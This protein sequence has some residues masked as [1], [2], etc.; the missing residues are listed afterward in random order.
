[1][2]RKDAGPGWFVIQLFILELKTILRICVMDRLTVSKS[3]NPVC[4]T[5]VRLTLQSYRD[6]H[7][8]FTH[9]SRSSTPS[10]ESLILWL[11]TGFSGI[12]A[13]I[14][15]FLFASM[16]MPACLRAANVTYTA[17]IDTPSL[18]S[19]SSASLNVQGSNLPC[20]FQEWSNSK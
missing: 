2:A 8:R 20:F 5:G 1:M 19:L 12:K 7:G 3:L 18:P 9:K 14:F 6:M 17:G 11:A 10:F 4:H 13:V 15:V 16:M